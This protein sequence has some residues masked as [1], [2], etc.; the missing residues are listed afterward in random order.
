MDINWILARARKSPI[1]VNTPDNALKFKYD[2][3]SDVS[4]FIQFIMQ[5][6]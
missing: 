1:A 5:N 4:T 3:S 2:I 6:I